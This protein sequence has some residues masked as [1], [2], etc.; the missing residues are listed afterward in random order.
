ML[1]FYYNSSQEIIFDRKNIIKYYD[2]LK[3]IHFFNL[4]SFPVFFFYKYCIFRGEERRG[5][6][7]LRFKKSSQNT[8]LFWIFSQC[9]RDSE[10]CK[11][12]SMMKMID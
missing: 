3:I 12:Y 5:L 1:L 4:A 2:K 9:N 11:N 6:S 7:S 10:E 8:S